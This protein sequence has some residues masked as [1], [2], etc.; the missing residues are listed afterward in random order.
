MS[1]DKKDNS[2]HIN[3]IILILTTVSSL[4]KIRD[5]FFNYYHMEKEIM[6]FIY[7]PFSSPHPN[8]FFS[9]EMENISNLKCFFNSF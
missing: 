3:T 9:Q 6:K 5:F 1:F 7:N 2:F 4:S 8:F